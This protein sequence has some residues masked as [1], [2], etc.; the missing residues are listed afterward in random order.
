MISTCGSD[1]KMKNVILL[2]MISIGGKGYNLVDSSNAYISLGR[3]Y[4]FEM[5]C[6]SSY[7][8]TTYKK[9]QTC[10]KQ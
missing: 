5:F 2:L 9:K 3:T 1:A 8:N 6:P 10:I 4:A 7:G